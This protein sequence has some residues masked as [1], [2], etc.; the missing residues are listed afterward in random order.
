[1]RA[2]LQKNGPAFAKR[3]RKN[4]KFVK[5]VTLWLNCSKRYEHLFCRLLKAMKKMI[6]YSEIL[7]IHKMSNWL[8]LRFF[9]LLGKYWY[10]LQSKEIIKAFGKV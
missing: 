2:Q 6:R 8:P 10:F 4:T 1:M 7:R 9:S 5:T 3:I